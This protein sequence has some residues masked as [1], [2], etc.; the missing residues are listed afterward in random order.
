MMDCQPIQHC[1]QSSRNRPI[2]DKVLN[3]VKFY[4]RIAVHSPNKHFQENIVSHKD[5]FD[6]PFNCS[7]KSSTKMENVY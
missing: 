2:P 1:R 4:S 7:G 6:I 5:F 3:F